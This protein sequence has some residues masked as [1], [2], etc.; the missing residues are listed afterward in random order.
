VRRLILASVIA[1]TPFTG[2]LGSAEAVCAGNVLCASQRNCY[3]IVNVCP[4]A[5][6]C[7]GTVNVCPNAGTCGGGVNVCDLRLS[8]ARP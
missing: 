1:L 8:G 6:E 2:F 5:W 4:G 7:Y 3:G